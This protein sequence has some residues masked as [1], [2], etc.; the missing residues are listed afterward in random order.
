MNPYETD[1]LLSEYLLFHYGEP[2]EVL[3]EEF[4]AFC[5]ADALGFAARAVSET[6]EWPAS[7]TLPA[8]S[9]AMEW[10]AL[11]LG[12]A[13]G[14]SSFELARHCREVVGIDFSHRFIDAANRLR[15]HGSLDFER[16]DEG[17]LTTRLTARVSPEIDR[18]RVAFEQGDATA[19]RE[20]LGTFDAVLAANLLC[21][22]REPERC[23]QQFAGL[24]RPGGQLVVTTPCTW[25][26]DFTPRDHWLGGLERGGVRLTTLAGLRAA[27]DPAFELRRTLNLP[28]L[29]REHAR[30]YQWSVA[31][32]SVWFR[33]EN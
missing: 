20:G 21:R 5:P 1:R 32:A 31:Q 13:V 11:D 26:D 10:R 17:I 30:K 18:S 14:R 33:R 3:P 15:R 25:L 7:S 2:A 22:L 8:A 29:I 4:R 16:T 28:F 12:C 24:V 9:G 19:L 6:F 23:L 27:L